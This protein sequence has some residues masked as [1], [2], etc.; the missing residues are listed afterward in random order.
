MFV[1][2]MM[3]LRRPGG[4]KCNGFIKK[5]AASD[6][7]G[8]VPTSV[9]ALASI[10]TVAE[11]LP[12]HC[13]GWYLSLCMPSPTSSSASQPLR[14]HSGARFYKCDSQV[15]TPRDGN[16]TGEFGTITSNADRKA[17]AEVGVTMWQACVARQQ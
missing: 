8:Y 6:G 2:L 10:E 17:Y 7:S 11:Q 5:T 3:W 14:M 1:V 13:F 4:E 16:W 15:Q 12:R 9:G